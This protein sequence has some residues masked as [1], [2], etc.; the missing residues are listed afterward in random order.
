MVTSSQVKQSRHV[1][2]RECL[3]VVL[4]NFCVIHHRKVDCRCN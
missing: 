4:K 2:P 1:T 3:V